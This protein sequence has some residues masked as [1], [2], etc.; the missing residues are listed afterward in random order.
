M[1]HCCAGFGSIVY[2]LRQS[3]IELQNNICQIS[4]VN[5]TV[6]IMKETLWTYS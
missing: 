1:G 4:N 3:V 6:Y 5:I 2:K